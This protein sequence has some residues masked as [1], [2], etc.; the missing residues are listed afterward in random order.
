MATAYTMVFERHAQRLLNPFRGAVHTLRYG[1]AEAVTADGVHWHIYVTNEELLP[2]GDGTRRVQ[3]GDMRFGSWSAAHGLRRGRLS[4]SE[5]FRRM[6]TVGA[7]LYEYLTQ[8]HEKIP[9][10]FQ[11]HLE[12]WLLT[13]EARPL[14]LLNSALDRHEM[15]LEQTIQWRAGFAARESFFSN[16]MENLATNIALAPAASDYLAHY[17]NTRAGAPPAAQWFRRAADGSGTGLSD[18]GLSPA[19]IGRTLA[20][21]LFPPL[22]LEANN[23]DGAHR[24]L[25]ADFQAWQ[26][27]WLLLLPQLDRVTRRAFEQHACH[28]A[29]VVEQQ[30][31]LYPEIIDTAAIQAARVEAVMRRSQLQP[32]KKEDILSTFYIEL[33]PSGDA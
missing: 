33:S 7:C 6:E 10:V 15:D 2:D 27:P 9:F 3:I 20:R 21:D 14:A 29:L 25:I 31:R 12:L 22:F 26:A 13:A 1:S 32:E 8:V 4:P 24:Q 30:F 28:Q 5:D 19:L 23:H 16:A 17:I 18:I 11:D